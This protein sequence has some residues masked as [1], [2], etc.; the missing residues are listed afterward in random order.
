M[1]IKQLK[2]FVEIV[3]SDFNISETSKKIHISQPALS[4]MI[5]NFEREENVQLF[6]R[7]YGRLI[8][9]TPA[10]ENFYYNAIE[11][12]KQHEEMMEGLR[13]AA[14]EAKGKIK[15]G[16]P[17]LVLTVLF[18]E[19]IPKL[20]L[21]YPNIQFEILEIGALELKK[22]LVLQEVDIAILLNPTD[23]NKT[24]IEKIIIAD[25]DL[26]AFMSKDNKLANNKKL[27]WS[28]LNNENLAIFSESFMINNYLMRKFDSESVK[29]NIKLKSNSWDYLLYSTESNNLI[30]I[31]PSPMDSFAHYENLVKLE[32]YDPIN[33]EVI[34]CR[35][36]KNRYS[37]IETLIHNELIEYFKR[38]NTL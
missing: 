14:A 22:S 7:S 12:L 9:L 26:C 17:P 20:I 37:R 31:L 34:L 29:P 6:E 30:T 33:W 8:G 15:I 10:G 19:I 13:H 38:G 16:I 23:F 5:I 21:K 1:D 28:D 18:S 35:Y 32:F 3:E 2:N 11:L 4:K 36:K 25:D 27:H 24:T